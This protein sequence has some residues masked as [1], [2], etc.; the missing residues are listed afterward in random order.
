MKKALL[1]PVKDPERAKTRLAGLLSAEERRALAWAMFED[2]TR[3]ASS[4]RADMVALVTSY[5]PALER[6]RRLGWQSLIERSQATESASI[7]WASLKLA[8]MGFDAVMR[9]PADVPT[10]RAEDID[11]LLRVDLPPRAALMVPS[12]EG[13]GTNAIIRTPPCL[14]PS[15]FGPDSLSLHK[16]EAARV[17]ARCVIVENARIALDIDEPSD[18]RALIES[19]SDTQTHRLLAAM[20]IIERMKS[21]QD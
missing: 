9:L 8:E 19:R 11:A 16:A 12:R 15:R 3:A 1:I 20:N 13:T 5:E 17:G 14:F 10:V 2:V 21:G 4:A 6:A 18:I 7:D